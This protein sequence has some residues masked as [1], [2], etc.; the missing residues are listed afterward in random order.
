[1]NGFH[2]VTDL[3][4]TWIPDEGHIRHLRLLESALRNNPANVLTFASG[5][6]FDS[7]RMAMQKWALMEPDHL[8]TDVGCA[9]WHRTPDGTYEEDLPYATMIEDRWCDQDAE[10]LL[11]FWLPKT[12]QKQF[13]VAS[14]RRLALEPAPGVPLEEASRD[15]WKAMRSCGMNADVLS[16]QGRYLD[17]LPTGVDKGFAVA[18]LQATFHLP[19][20][21]VCCGDSARDIGMLRNADYPILMGDGFIDFEAP[22]IPRDRTYR[23]PHRGPVGIHAALLSFGLLEAP[24]EISH[25][26]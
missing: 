6:T 20:P 1:M 17:V 14:V 3:D 23:T 18:F 13:G 11:G 7:A 5:R 22:G 9:L 15:L 10:R 2:L 25:E 12:V 21:L 4:G 16:S 26:N 19:R 8:I 24:E